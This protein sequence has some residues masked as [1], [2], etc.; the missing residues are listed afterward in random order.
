MESEFTTESQCLQ[1]AWPFIYKVV[2]VNQR[3][4][5]TTVTFLEM[6]RGKCCRTRFTWTPREVGEIFGHA[7]GPRK[8]VPYL[9]GYF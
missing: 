4:R 2:G 7:L 6:R 5:L 1:S 9:H 3:R 8:L